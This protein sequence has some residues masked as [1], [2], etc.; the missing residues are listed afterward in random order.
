MF[1]CGVTCLAIMICLALYLR[2]KL[3][4]EYLSASEEDIE[5]NAYSS[6]KINDQ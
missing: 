4:G 5:M 2:N 1:V 3:K 6:E